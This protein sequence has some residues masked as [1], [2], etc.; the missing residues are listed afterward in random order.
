[1]PPITTLVALA[2]PTRC[3]IL[4]ILRLGPQPVHVLAASFD[5]SRP[6]ISR[7]LRVLK[8]ARLISEKKLGRENRYALHA[9]RLQP[10]R[11]WLAEFTTA[12]AAPA[13]AKKAKIAPKPAPKP[14]TVEIASSAAHKPEP[15]VQPPKARQAPAASQMGFDF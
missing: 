7:H 6:A 5:I 11:E 8:Q 4:E 14:V 3:R 13:A 10:V 9:N 1:M 12:A 15:L 2:D